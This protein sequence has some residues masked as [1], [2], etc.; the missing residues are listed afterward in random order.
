MVSAD[1]AISKFGVRIYSSIGSDNRLARARRQA[2]V[3]TNAGQ[4][5]DAYILHTTPMS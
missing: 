5:T 1:A 2:I 3:W 4:F